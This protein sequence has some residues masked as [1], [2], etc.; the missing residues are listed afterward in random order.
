MYQVVDLSSLQQ[1]G[2][3]GANSLTDTGTD[4]PEG[5][6]ALDTMK[7]TTVPNRNMLMLSV[8]FS[9]AISLQV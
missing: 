8:A 4:I 3:F 6:Y 5:H 2:L 7:S 1:A 9:Y